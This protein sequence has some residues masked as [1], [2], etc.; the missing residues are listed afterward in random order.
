VVL[1]G[2]LEEKEDLEDFLDRDRAWE[3]S[4]TLFLPIVKIG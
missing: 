4:P 3:D 2:A 1:E